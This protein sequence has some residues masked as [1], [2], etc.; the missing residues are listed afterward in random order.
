MV[1]YT[2]IDITNKLL[3]ANVVMQLDSQN[4]Y[5]Y[6]PQKLANPKERE[7]DYEAVG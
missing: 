5:F 2:L 3:M 1:S 4:G 6:D 7:I